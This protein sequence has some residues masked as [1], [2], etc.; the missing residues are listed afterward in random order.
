[1]TM[2]LTGHNTQDDDNITKSTKRLGHASRGPRTFFKNNPFLEEHMHTTPSLGT[3]GTKQKALLL[4]L[5]GRG[6]SV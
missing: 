3:S 5:F 2:T 4:G 1:M 6:A